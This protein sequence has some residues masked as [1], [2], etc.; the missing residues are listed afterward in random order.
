M[1]NTILFI[2]MRDGNERTNSC[3]NRPVV[4]QNV[5]D[6][7]QVQN[8]TKS[9]HLCANKRTYDGVCDTTYTVLHQ[10]LKIDCLNFLNKN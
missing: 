7:L 4:D 10:I 5:W 1:V 6:L 2:D 3:G 8:S 9:P